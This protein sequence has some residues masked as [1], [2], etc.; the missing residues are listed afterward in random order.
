[1]DDVEE[2]ELG[3]SSGEEDMLSSDT[4]IFESKPVD[5]E[6]MEMEKELQV[7]LKSPPKRKMMMKMYADE[8]EEQIQI[9][10]YVKF[11]CIYIIR[12]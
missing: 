8:V 10:R 2:G 11:Y 4:R 9:K 5:E 12:H 3:A 1:M 7:L 6:A